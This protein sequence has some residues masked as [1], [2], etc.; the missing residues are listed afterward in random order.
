MIYPEDV[1]V[2][3]SAPAL[4]V[5]VPFDVNTEEYDA[6]GDIPEV[7][8]VTFPPGNTVA[9]VVMLSVPVALVTSGMLVAP[10]TGGRNVAPAVFVP[11]PGT[12]KFG[13]GM[14]IVGEGME[15]LKALV[16]GKGGVGPVGSANVAVAFA[17]V[18]T[19]AGPVAL[20]KKGP[21]GVSG[22]PMGGVKLG[23]A[24][25]LAT[26]RAIVIST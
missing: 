8:E 20:G 9:T 1:P 11:P 19:L 13:P 10:G 22:A 24:V 17:R 3:V 26:I 6:V 15:V 2:P 25:C 4:A 7:T 5:A 23:A 18:V 12:V 21:V 14:G 16:P